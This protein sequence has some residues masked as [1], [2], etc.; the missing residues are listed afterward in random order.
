MDQSDLYGKVY[1]LMTHQQFGILT[2]IGSDGPHSSLIAFAVTN[3]LK[4]VLF[5]TLQETRK[6]ANIIANPNVSLLVD[7]R[8]AN[9]KEIS[10]C[11]ALSAYG[12]V[13]KVDL[14]SAVA[15][16]ELFAFCHPELAQ[17]LDKPTYSLFSVSIKKYEVING[18]SE[19]YTY[20]VS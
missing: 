12:T 9:S 7:N 18:L 20:Q 17:Y 16:K 13:K 15:T 8:P 14:N 10:G 19:V 1:E 6:Y 4:T 2:S 3:N 11:F 5:M